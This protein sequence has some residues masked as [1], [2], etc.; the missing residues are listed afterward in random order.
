MTRILLELGVTFDQMG[1]YFS[2]LGLVSRA[3]DPVVV[4]VA[5]YLASRRLDLPFHY[6]PALLG[7]FLGAWAGNYVGWTAGFGLLSSFPSSVEFWVLPAVFFSLPQAVG[8]LFVCFTAASLAYLRRRSQAEVATS[9][10]GAGGEEPRD[11]KE[12]RVSGLARFLGAAGQDLAL[13]NRKVLLLAFIV[14]VTLGFMGSYNQRLWEILAREGEI[15][16]I[17]TYQYHLY[18][19]LILP[20]LN[21]ILL[22]AAVYLASRRVE[23]VSRYRAVVLS[24]FLGGWVG[25]SLG[26]PAGS[27]VAGSLLG[28]LTMF[29]PDFS[30]IGSLSTTLEGA[31]DIVFVGFTAAS[32][33]FL[34]KTARTHRIE[35]DLKREEPPSARVEAATPPKKSTQGVR[36]RWKVVFGLIAMLVVAV[37]VG[38]L[39]KEE[40]AVP[41]EVLVNTTTVVSVAD[42]LTVDAIRLDKGD[43]VK[44]GFR[45]LPGY[46][47]ACVNIRERVEEGGESVAFK[48]LYIHCGGA[49]SFVWTALNDGTYLI[50]FWSG[51]DG[52]LT[53]I[54]VVINRTPS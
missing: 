34:R 45:V 15:V 11:S 25:Y 16:R 7:L 40:D 53:E 26:Q 28:S 49:H 2:A 10:E 24:L 41:G 37:V 48:N 4:F 23:L 30:V 42:P 17:F 13:M 8:I 14:S 5:V 3:I 6:K 29:G 9:E 20:L 35:L 47:D 31:V 22:L 54:S 1:L 12:R 46:D 36:T 33:R 21:R 52:T 19:S 43:S 50:E 51:E 18:S 32:L 27:A 44:V 38:S 39:I